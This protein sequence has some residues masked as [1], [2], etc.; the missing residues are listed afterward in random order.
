MKKII[1]I[2]SIAAIASVALILFFVLSK[3]TI[4]EE[5]ILS[6]DKYIAAKSGLNLRSNPDKTSSVVTLIPFGSMVTIEKSEGDEIFLDGT[7]G[8]WVNVKFGNKTGW[9]FSGFLC[10]FEPNTI[11]KPVAD[12]Y[13][14]EY[15]KDADTLKDKIE[16]LSERYKELAKFEDNQVSIINILDNYIILE[17][18]SFYSHDRNVVWRYNAKKKNFFEAHKGEEQNRAY[19][20]YLDNDKYPDLII[21]KGRGTESI[22]INILLGSKNGFIKIFD[23]YDFGCCDMHDPYFSLSVGSCGDMKFEFSEDGETM[24]FFRFNCNNRKFEK[25]AESKITSLKGIITSID[26]KNMSI[27]IKDEKDLKEILFKIHYYSSSISN[28]GAKY[29]KKLQNDKNVVPFEY[30]TI[31][32]EKKIISIDRRE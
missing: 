25:Y 30:V 9:L 18:P 7:Y 13:R 22:G 11:I 16:W 8:K 10:D 4:H 28:E 27:V 14:N 32:G 12:Y 2:G 23:S 1:L 21:Y 15:R 26:L 29:L 24:Y 17:I 31:D 6:G 19:F 20:L 5:I 3:N